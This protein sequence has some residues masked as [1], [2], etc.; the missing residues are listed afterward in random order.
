VLRPRGVGC[1]EF[2]KRGLHCVQVRARKDCI[3]LREGG[4]RLHCVG[5]RR[6]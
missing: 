5:V 2:R 3:V 1:I 6:G 4:D